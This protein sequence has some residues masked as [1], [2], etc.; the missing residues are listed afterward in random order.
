[1]V[2]GGDVSQKGTLHNALGRVFQKWGWWQGAMGGGSP[3][4]RAVATDAD[5][6]RKMWCA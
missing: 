1:M 2:L 3:V 4:S 6:V 5:E